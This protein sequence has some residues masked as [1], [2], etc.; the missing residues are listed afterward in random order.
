MNEHVICYRRFG[1][2]AEVLQVEQRPLSEPG[3]GE[4]RTRVA[5][6]IINPSDLIP[7]RGSYAHRIELPAVPG[8]EGVG[9]IEA[10]GPGVS[11]AWIGRRVLPLRGAGTWQDS[12]ISPAVWAV[13]VPDELPDEAAC[14]LFINPVTA[15]VLCTEVL[16][17]KPGDILLMNAANSSLG[18]IFA[19]LSAILGFRFAAVIREP[20]QAS[21]LYS[22]GA[23]QVMEA[24]RHPATQGSLID[25]VERLTGGQ[26][27]RAAID[28]VGG[29]AA[30]ELSACIA[31]GG[32]FLSL[33][34]LSGEPVPEPVYAE[35]RIESRLFHLRHWMRHVS[36]DAWQRTFAILIGLF[37]RRLLHLAEVEQIFELKHAVDAVRAA[38]QRG[39]RGKIMLVSRSGRQK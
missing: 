10:V 26:G 8:Y 31:A 17:L 32:T 39:R 21:R 7:I 25:T 27:I 1:E 18:A 15:W 14:Q 28:C 12:V 5:A 24:S 36:P 30:A 11:P 3:I 20:Q 23:W 4:I 2:P 16:Q 35:R 19:Q 34:L 29:A 6:R 38:E 37:K 33:G 9:V 13:P 22:L